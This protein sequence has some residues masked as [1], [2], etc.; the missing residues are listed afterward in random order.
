MKFISVTLWEHPAFLTSL[1]SILPDA[2][3][4]SLSHILSNT[5]LPYVQDLERICFILS[6]NSCLS[7]LGNT[8]QIIVVLAT[9]YT[10]LMWAFFKTSKTLDG[11]LR[12]VAETAEMIFL[13]VLM[14][15]LKNLLFIEEKEEEEDDWWARTVGFQL[16]IFYYQTRD[17]PRQLLFCLFIEWE[18]NVN[19]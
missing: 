1:Q 3:E 18:R 9:G 12:Y 5:A 16:Q 8:V 4:G 11:I 15:N 17:N 14:N 19:N 10:A 2:K 13:Q 7:W 6:Y